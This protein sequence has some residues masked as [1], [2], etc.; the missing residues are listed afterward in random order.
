MEPSENKMRSL[1]PDDVV[2]LRY[3]LSLTPDLKAFIFHG[4]ISVDVEVKKSTKLIKLHCLEIEVKSMTAFFDAKRPVKQITYDVKEETISVEFE[5]VLPIGKGKLEIEYQG[6]LNNSMMGFYRSKYYLNGEERYMAVTQ[7]EPTGAR[8]AFPCWDEPA[9][10]A[11]FEVQL[12]IPKDLVALSNMDPVSEK[13]EDDNK[14]T[15]VFAP[16][17]VMSTY[18]L[19]VVVGEFEY[20][21]GKTPENV[22]VRVYTPLEKKQSG[23]FALDVAIRTLSYYSEYFNISYPLPKLDMIAVA[24]FAAG[25]ME[26]WGLVTYREVALLID[27]KNSGIAYKKRVAYV[28]AHELA[29]QWFGNLVTMQWWKE[30]WLNEGFATFIG[31]QAVAHLFPQWDMWTQFLSDYMNSALDLDSLE[32]SHPIEVEVYNSAQ[33]EEI[34]DTISYKKGASVIRML[35]NRIGEAAFRKGLTIYLKRFQYKNAVT[36]DLWNAL[37]EVAN[38]DVKSF[39]DNYTKTTGYPLITVEATA[40][41]EKFV[42]SQRRFF[43]NGKVLNPYEEQLWWV[44]IPIVSSKS[45]SVSKHDLLTKQEILQFPIKDTE[46]FKL[47]AGQSGFFRVRY[48]EEM[49]QRLIPAISSKSLSAL[50][51]IGLENDAFALSIAGVIPATQVLSLV[52]AFANESEYTVWEDICSHLLSVGFLLSSE[53]FYAD[54][55]RFV[56]NLLTPIKNVL[57]WDAKKGES[58]LDTLLRSAILNCM[59][60]FGDVETIAEA[61]KR[62]Q[63]FIDKG[64]EIVADLRG[65]IYRTVVQYG[66]EA[67][68]STMLS[69]YRRTDQ[70]HQEKL[71]AFRAL[72]FANRVSLIEETLSLL[73]TEE[74]RSQDIYIPFMCFSQMPLA[75]DIAWRYLREHWDTIR[76]RIGGAASILEHV[77]Q[78]TT[79]TFAYER[80][81]EEM[82]SFFDAHPVANAERSIRQNI[83]KILTHSKWLNENREDVSKWL[84][85]Q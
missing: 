45:Q 48:S 21:E 13:E 31:T 75:K 41:E 65:I 58:D 71:R 63:N 47:N 57:G 5:E 79:E 49:S 35:S 50:D 18:L 85:S 25:A 38:V 3:R 82:K 78:G 16:S 83:E 54:Y 80:Y 73:M 42:V 46:W 52:K 44:S 4:H 37:S 32:N 33:I 56:R 66:G 2:P 9:H 62:F 43:S 24:D 84:T 40:A 81:A 23:S 1:L 76:N 10:K 60:F 14:K 55:E 22:R 7:F 51:R 64:V 67:E 68:Y 53:R 28:V 77:I 29:H 15:V 8:R 11:V 6:V 12:T 34:F 61:K 20:I 70:P 26:N 69:L 39:M 27:E 74:V 59:S 17:P 19:A 72:A 30:L 36:E